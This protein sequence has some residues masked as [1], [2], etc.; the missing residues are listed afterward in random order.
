MAFKFKT[1]KSPQAKFPSSKPRVDNGNFEEALS[2]YVDGYP[3][4]RD[5]EFFMTEAR[6]LGSV[7]SSEFRKTLG[8]P[9]YMPGWLELDALIETYN[10]YRA[11][12]IDDMSFVHLGQ[13]EAAETVVK[14]GRRKEGLRK[15]GISINK[16]EHIDAA[17]LT[18]REE[19]RNVL[20]ELRL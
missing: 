4:K 8:A 20:R 6:K 10:G 11:F 7:R 19:A 16:V 2:G 18:T 1:V 17:K 15:I 12:E 13:R 9:R 3:A 5:E 14:D